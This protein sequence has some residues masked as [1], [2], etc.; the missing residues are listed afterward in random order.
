MN[1]IDF[2]ITGKNLNLIKQSNFS[3]PSF[4]AQVELFHFI[5]KL[6]YAKRAELSNEH[7]L[8]CEQMLLKKSRKKF[9]RLLPLKDDINQLLDLCFI[10][11]DFVCFK[12]L[13][14]KKLFI[15]I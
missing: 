8:K 7:W 15:F 6:M 5:G 4:N 10:S 13:Y 11:G 12:I 1:S 3:S 14:K 2:F 9:G